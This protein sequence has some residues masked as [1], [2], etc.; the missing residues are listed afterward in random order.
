MRRVKT[1]RRKRTGDTNIIPDKGKGKRECPKMAKIVLR[2]SG[3]VG[4]KKRHRHFD[5]LNEIT[6]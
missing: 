2:P 5:D 3:A 4:S 6:K 1:M